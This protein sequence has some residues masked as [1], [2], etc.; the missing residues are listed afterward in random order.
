[1]CLS[2]LA[3][4]RAPANGQKCLCNVD[5]EYWKRVLWCLNWSYCPY[6]THKNKCEDNQYWILTA[7]V[8]SGLLHPSASLLG[9]DIEN[10]SLQQSRQ[11]KA[12][13]GAHYNAHH[14]SRSGRLPLPPNS[15]SLL[16]APGADV[17]SGVPPQL[18]TGTQ[19]CSE[20]RQYSLNKSQR[21]GT[22]G[23]R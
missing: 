22:L 14:A 9:T 1:M 10:G 20:K 19:S 6:T 17:K 16:R 21:L 13:P 4:Q 3:N 7:A 18:L 2:A 8:T 5:I 15:L 12:R 11:C 23:N